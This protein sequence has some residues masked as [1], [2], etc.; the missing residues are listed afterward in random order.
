MILGATDYSVT[1]QHCTAWK[2]IQL[3]VDFTV[4]QITCFI[5]H[6]THWSFWLISVTK[7]STSLFSFIQ[8]CI[9]KTENSSGGWVEE[10]ILSRLCINILSTVGKEGTFQVCFP[11]FTLKSST[12]PWQGH[13]SYCTCTWCCS[14]P[15]AVPAIFLCWTSWH[16][17]QHIASACPSCFI[18]DTTELNSTHCIQRWTKLKQHLHPRRVRGTLELGITKPELVTCL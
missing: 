17:C 12:W 10:M 6:A 2:N 3:Q 7:H 5:I 4:V 11:A 13:V 14:Y 1:F 9:A 16:F 15:V 18:P 8:Q